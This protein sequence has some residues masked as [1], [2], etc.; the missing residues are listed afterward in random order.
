MSG[1]GKEIERRIERATDKAHIREI[2]RKAMKVVGCAW[3][4]GERK[5]RGDFRRRM[6]MFECMEEEEEVE[7]VQ[8][9]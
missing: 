4:I 2:V 5:R 1:T 3:G 7:K 9:E 8:E 6:M